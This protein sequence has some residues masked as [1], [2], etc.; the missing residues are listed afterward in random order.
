MHAHLHPEVEL[1]EQQTGHLVDRIERAE[2]PTFVTAWEKLPRC[3]G[4][5]EGE[6]G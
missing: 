1:L 3:A 6:G 5:A 4:H 2:F